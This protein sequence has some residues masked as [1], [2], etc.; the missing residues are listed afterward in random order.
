MPKLKST[1]ADAKG[2]NVSNFGRVMLW[3]GSQALINVE[4]GI[5]YFT[6]LREV[7]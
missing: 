7:L 6:R 2:T 5:D 1:L 4:G 3:D